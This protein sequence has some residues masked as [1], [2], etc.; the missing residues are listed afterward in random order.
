MITTKEAV[1]NFSV[2]SPITLL[3]NTAQ[4][5]KLPWLYI[6]K[7]SQE[8][9]LFDNTLFVIT[10]SLESYLMNVHSQGFFVWCE[11]EV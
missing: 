8:F 11:T 5:I 9:N 1:A 6:K 10:D 4:K 2:S 3:G 7:T